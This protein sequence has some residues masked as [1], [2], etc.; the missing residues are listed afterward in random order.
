MMVVLVMVLVMM[1][2]GNERLKVRQREEI[3]MAVETR[4]EG[5]LVEGRSDDGVVIGDRRSGDGGNDGENERRVEQRRRGVGIG[6]RRRRRPNARPETTGRS[7]GG[8][9]MGN[10]TWTRV[11]LVF[12]LC[13]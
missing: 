10:D 6:V 4:V 7:G 5:V 8:E 13:W 9:E 2:V 11:R 3:M 1:V 12:S